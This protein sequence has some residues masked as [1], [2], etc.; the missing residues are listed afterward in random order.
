MNGCTTM[1]TAKAT[2]P[3]PGGYCFPLGCLPLTLRA[4]PRTAKFESRATFV[5][6]SR[7]W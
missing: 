7:G 1:R 3:L 2:M 4:Q 6:G 5:N